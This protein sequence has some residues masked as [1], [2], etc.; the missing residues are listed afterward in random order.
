MEKPFL[1]GDHLAASGEQI[2]EA[3]IENLLPRYYEAHGTRIVYEIAQSLPVDGHDVAWMKW[4]GDS[5][6][7]GHQLHCACAFTEGV[8]WRTDETY[9]AVGLGGEGQCEQRAVALG[10]RIEQLAEEYRE[11]FEGKTATERLQ[12]AIIDLIAK[13][14]AGEF[15]GEGTNGAHFWGGH[16]YLQTVGEIT[17]VDLPDLWPCVDTMVARKQIQLDGMVV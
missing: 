9:G 16:F 11:R 5:G 1:Q 10:R 3:R 15:I 13:D 12:A 14:K 4:T 6:I 7:T 2:Q 8:G 17:G